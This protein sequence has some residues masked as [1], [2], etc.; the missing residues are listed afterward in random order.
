MRNRAAPA[1]PAGTPRA[2]D[3]A[4]PESRISLFP[5]AAGFGIFQCITQDITNH[6]KQIDY[7]SDFPE[8]EK[9]AARPHAADASHALTGIP[10]VFPNPDIPESGRYSMQFIRPVS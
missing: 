5:C 10:H 2:P 3:R 8:V 7:S 9:S 6:Y 4:T 1:M